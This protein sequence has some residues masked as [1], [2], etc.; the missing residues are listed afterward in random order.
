[1]TRALNIGLYSEFF[2]STL[3]GGEK[4]FGVAAEA[5]HERWPQ[6]RLELVTRVPVDVRRYECELNLDLGGI[7]PRVLPPR[8]TSWPHRIGAALLRPAP[9]YR[10]LLLIAPEA[11]FTRRYDLLLP[12]VYVHRVLSRARSTVMLCQFPYEYGPV[13]FGAGGR[14]KRLYRR[15]YHAL[16]GWLLGGEV[17]GMDMVICQSDYVAACIRDYWG[18][19]PVIVN[20]PI[21]IPERDPD[22]EGKAPI[23]LSVGRFFVGG[24][25][26]RH[27]AMMAAFRELCDAG[28]TGW[29]LHLA[30]SLHHD[31]PSASHFE[32]LRRQ[33]AGY[34]IHL[35]GDAP[36]DELQQLYRRASIYWHAS[37]YGVDP[38]EHPANVE[39]FGMTTAEAM[40][41]GAVP[42]VIRVGGQPEIVE[43]GRSGFL[44]TTLE[45]LKSRT[46]ELVG[47]PGQRFQLGCAARE[48]SRRF[49]RRHFKRQIADHLA[50]VVA[51]LESDL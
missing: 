48:S 7:V 4:Y 39:H 32:E 12:M 36:Y 14:A 37:G 13:Q 43:D 26:K 21:D 15:P 16:R 17:P 50:P 35:H 1:M 34:P 38:D 46:R 40:A 5:I 3:G 24:H 2:G 23:I 8:R 10:D 18:I 44:W 41:N 20:P 11:Q 33:A 31:Q 19:D 42:V 51:R 29:E 6:H 22:W 9:I 47:N 45:E 49:E 27:D 30:G 25:N 28:L